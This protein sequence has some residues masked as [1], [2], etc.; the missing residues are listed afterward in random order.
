M[1]Y[2]TGY[3]CI[4]NYQVELT[5]VIPVYNGEDF[6]GT[7]VE[8]VLSHSTGFNVECLVIDDGSNDRTPEILASFKG[9]IRV[10]RQANAGE[11]AAVNRGL[12]LALGDYVV[13]VSADDPVLTPK[14]FEDVTLFFKVNPRVVAWYPDW[15]II[16][17]NGSDLRQIFLPEY[18]FNDLFSRNKVLPG[19]GT[20]IRTEAALAIGGRSTKWKYVGDYDF[21]LRLSQHGMLVHRPGIFAQWRS[22]ARS[23]SISE[24]GPQMAR[25]RIQVIEEFIEEY[26]QNIDPKMKSLARA[27]ASYLAAKLGFFSREVNS[28]KL[29]FASFS[30]D[31]RIL[32]YAKPRELAFML[33]FPL[34]K[35]TIDFFSSLR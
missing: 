27:H 13:I 35:R 30:H 14:L 21:W 3:A 33:T 17:E 18:T 2:T 8:S 10:H 12:E 11:G 22:H 24:R 34:S 26:G 29:I 9:Q 31:L 7:T 6:I 16:D 15:K 28:R 5:V 1:G 25:E 23:T 4:V 20:W 19:P 32:R